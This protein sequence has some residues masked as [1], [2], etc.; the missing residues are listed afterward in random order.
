MGAVLGGMNHPPV[1]LLKLPISLEVAPLS[2]QPWVPGRVV[3]WGL[4][5]PLGLLPRAP[6][7]SASHT[8]NFLFCKGLSLGLKEGEP[9]S[10]GEQLSVNERG[11]ETLKGVQLINNHRGRSG[12]L[13]PGHPG[14]H[15]ALKF[16]WKGDRPASQ[17]ILV[18]GLTTLGGWEVLPN[19]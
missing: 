18:S 10:H 15:Q 11:R 13:C 5:L 4:S 19:V 12:A 14:S 17:I 9:V 16:F 2:L 1:L 3:S 8:P 6:H 7:I